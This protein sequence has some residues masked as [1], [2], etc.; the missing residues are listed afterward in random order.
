MCKWSYFKQVVYLILFMEIVYLGILHHELTGV[1][2][3]VH[4]EVSSEQATQAQQ[5]EG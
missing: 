1:H 4:M 5:G 2:R 3:D